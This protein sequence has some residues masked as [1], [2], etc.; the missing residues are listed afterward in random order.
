ST[1]ALSESQGRARPPPDRRHPHAVHRYRN[2]LRLRLGLAFRQ[3]FQNRP[4]HVSAAMPAERPGLG[5]AWAGLA[6]SCALWSGGKRRPAA[7]QVLRS[8]R[9]GEGV[10]G[11]LRTKPPGD[12]LGRLRVLQA[13]CPAR[14]TA[15]AVPLRGADATLQRYSMAFG[16]TAMLHRRQV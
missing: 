2:R 12:K 4:R 16:G 13:C 7:R 5:W 10:I 3:M 14:R 15:E 9:P 6:L 8:S 11:G 1:A